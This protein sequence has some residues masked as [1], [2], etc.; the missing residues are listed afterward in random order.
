MNVILLKINNV[1]KK[2]INEV[3]INETRLFNY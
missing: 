1:L 2:K 3:K